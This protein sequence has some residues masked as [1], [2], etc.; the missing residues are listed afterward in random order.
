[1]AHDDDARKAPVTGSTD[2]PNTSKREFLS[3]SGALLAVLG[4]ISTG[5][6]TTALA[7]SKPAAKPGAQQPNASVISERKTEIL[8]PNQAAQ[9][10]L[11][12]GEAMRSRN[13]DGALKLHGRGLSPELENALRQLS[14]ADL[15]AAAQL[16][17]KLG[18]LRN[19][20]AGDNIGI[21]GM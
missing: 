4:A 13:M 16:E 1:M 6:F 5:A 11:V 17:N 15:A 9:L 20:L 7:Q 3:K 18:S 12:M 10:K 21:I 14:P 19:K 2:E 8:A